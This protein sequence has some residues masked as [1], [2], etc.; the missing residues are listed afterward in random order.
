MAKKITES[1]EYFVNMTQN[2]EKDLDEIIVFIAQNNPQ[3]A[4]K[5]MEKIKV[6]INSL[7]HFP[8]RGTYVPELLKRNI[9]DYRQITENPWKIIYKINGNIVNVLTIIDSR[10]N[11][12]DI[13]IKKLLK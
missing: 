1:K 4:L 12:Q 10:R 13:L 5:I 9:K 8:Y 3:N 2:A 11:L 7:D 6:K